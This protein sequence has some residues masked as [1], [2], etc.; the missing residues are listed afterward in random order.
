MQSN[1]SK[2]LEKI[3]KS[4]LTTYL[5]KINEYLMLDLG[6]VDALYSITKYIKKSP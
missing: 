3:I 6:T 5:E 2:A 1:F 4:R